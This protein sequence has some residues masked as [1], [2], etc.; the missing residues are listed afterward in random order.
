M[1]S[2][3]R[4]F[5]NTHKHMHARTHKHT[6]KHAHNHTNTHT[7]TYTNRSI[8]TNTQTNTH[9]HPHTHL[10]T[11]KHLP[12]L[13][14]NPHALM[15]T[16]NRHT[17]AHT[18]KHTHTNQ[19]GLLILKDLLVWIVWCSGLL[20]STIFMCETQ[21]GFINSIRGWH[22]PHPRARAEKSMFPTGGILQSTALTHT[23]K[24][25]HTYTHMNKHTGTSMHTWKHKELIVLK[26]HRWLR[27]WNGS[28][29]GRYRTHTYTNTHPYTHT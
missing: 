6:Q 7:Q 4:L 26:S 29:H 14:T 16:K 9:I 10:R 8:H 27:K 5:L 15:H 21:N 13:Q 22:F 18:H 17:S 20:R 3:V 23:N 11:Q 12:T 25:T 19:T 1:L 2:K 28:T 24:L